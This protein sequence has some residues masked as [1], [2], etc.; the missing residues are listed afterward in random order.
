MYSIISTAAIFAAIVFNDIIQ[1]QKYYIRLHIF[2]GLI[3]TALVIVLWYLEYEY[4]A[5]GLIV[6][7]IF[8]L[9]I[10][11]IAVSTSSTSKKIQKTKVSSGQQLSDNSKSDAPTC[12]QNPAGEYTAVPQPST[13]SLPAAPIQPTTTGTVMTSPVSTP[14]Y[15]ITPITA[16]C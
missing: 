3:A 15:N 6:V 14:T 8:T 9:F 12:N 7:P 16:D 5:W 4:V 1:N 13:V 2:L 10:S 11:Y